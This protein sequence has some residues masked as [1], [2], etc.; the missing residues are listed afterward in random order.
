MPFPERKFMCLKIFGISLDKDFHSREY[1]LYA[2]VRVLLE[3]VNVD[4]WCLMD[5]PYFLKIKA[6]ISIQ[7]RLWACPTYHT[8]LYN[9]CVWVSLIWIILITAVA[10]KTSY[11]ATLSVTIRGSS[12]G[13]Q[14]RK[15]R[16]SGKNRTLLIENYFI[17][18]YSFHLLYKH[19]CLFIKVISRNMNRKWWKCKW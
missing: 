3:Q 1:I 17:K 15:I 6:T 13:S 10:S 2:H 4:V 12:P 5:I 14:W 19:I 11:F 16:K 9:T 7:I 18:L 8:L